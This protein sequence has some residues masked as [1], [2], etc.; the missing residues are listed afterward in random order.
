M[1]TNH[2]AIMHQEKIVKPRNEKTKARLTA[3]AY[4]F[5]SN[6]VVNVTSMYHLHH[7]NSAL[8]KHCDMRSTSTCATQKSGVLK[9]TSKHICRRHLRHVILHAEAEE[10]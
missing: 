10:D 4:R 1:K 7:L 3:R 9:V 5:A 2:A 8:Q 6:L